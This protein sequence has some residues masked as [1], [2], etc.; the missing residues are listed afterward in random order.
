MEETIFERRIMNCT[1]VLLH[2]RDRI[3]ELDGAVH[4]MKAREA[5]ERLALRRVELVAKEHSLERELSQLQASQLEF[6]SRGS[7]LVD[8]SPHARNL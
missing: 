1:L 7:A 6:K 5:R 8:D 3:K 2:A 4:H